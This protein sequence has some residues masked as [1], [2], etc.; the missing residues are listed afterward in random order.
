MTNVGEC[1]LVGDASL[2]WAVG[3]SGKGASHSREGKPCQ[4][5]YALW[6][7]AV[8]G[9]PCLIAAV[10]DGHGDDRHDLSHL[11]A[12]FA[13]KAAV[14][15]LFSLFTHCALEESP[16]AFKRTVKADF[17]RRVV[18]RWGEVVLADAG[19]QPRDAPDQL[20]D[21]HR[22]FVRYG[23]TLLAAVVTGDAVLLGQLGDGDVFV[24]RPDGS[25]ESP[26]PDTSDNIGTVTNSLCSANVAHLWRTAVLE[27]A[28]GGTLFLATDG[29]V[30]AFSDEQMHTFARSLRERIQEFGLDRVAASLPGWLDNYSAKGSGDDITLALASI[31]P[32]PSG[33]SVGKG[34]GQAE[35]KEN[36]S[37]EESRHAT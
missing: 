7:G 5:A 28:G 6:S 4:D 18:H 2:G 3:C 9:S 16:L 20:G 12:A 30:N 31:D 11:G 8:A 33:D 1:L 29:L 23:T 13:V 14:D 27:R 34:N 35:T 32:L 25:V 15:E 19:E 21:N 24:V 26:F 37:T 36:H 10:A 22:L 17:P